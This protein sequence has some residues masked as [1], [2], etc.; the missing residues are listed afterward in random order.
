MCTDKQMDLMIYL[1]SSLFW[2]GFFFLF[3]LNYNYY[4]CYHDDFLEAET[5]SNLLYSV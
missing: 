4:Y 1:L 2:V 5:L 3:F